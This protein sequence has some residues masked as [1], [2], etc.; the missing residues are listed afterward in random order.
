MSKFL[1]VTDTRFP[2]T[3]KDRILKKK[4][5]REPHPNLFVFLDSKSPL[6]LLGL[7]PTIVKPISPSI[8]L[9][10]FDYGQLMIF[11]WSETTNE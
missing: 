9:V 1:P 5:V 2:L 11:F 8:S 7:M 10:C 3:N 4:K 6:I